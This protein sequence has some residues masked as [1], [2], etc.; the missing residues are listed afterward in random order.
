MNSISMITGPFYMI[1]I[2]ILIGFSIY[3]LFKLFFS[4]TPDNKPESDLDIL[5]KRYASGKI[6]SEEFQKIKK[7][8]KGN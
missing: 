1:A 7:E 3:A 2:W 6:D 5:K 4:R 8:L